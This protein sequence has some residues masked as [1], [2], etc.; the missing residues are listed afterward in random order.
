VITVYHSERAR[1]VRVLWLLEE[2]SLPYQ[3][4]KLDFAPETLKSEEHLKRHPLGLVPVMEDDALRMFESGAML[5]YLL[6]SYGQGRLAPAVKSA[7]RG[8]YLQWFHFGEA[9]VARYL[10][11]IVRQRFRESDTPEISLARSRQ[12]FAASGAVVEQ[13]LKEREFICG[14]AF[15][16]ADIMVSYGLTIARMIRELPAEFVNVKAYLDRLRQRPAC[17]RAWAA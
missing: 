6:E 4:V 5:E 17:Q 10:S 14:S 1:S 12:R 13:A 2:L 15:S 7:Q 11:D 16:A 9:S 3:V 8:E